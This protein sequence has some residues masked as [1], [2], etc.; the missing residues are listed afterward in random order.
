MDPC[1]PEL[2]FLHFC[3]QPGVDAECCKRFPQAKAMYGLTGQHG[4]IC[5]S[6]QKHQQKQRCLAL[7]IVDYQGDAILTIWCGMCGMTLQRTTFHPLAA[8]C[9]P[10]LS[11]SFTK[12]NTLWLNGTIEGEG[13]IRKKRRQNHSAFAAILESS[14]QEQDQLRN[15][16][17]IQATCRRRS[18]RQNPGVPG[19]RTSKLQTFEVFGDR[20]QNR[21][22]KD[23]NKPPCFLKQW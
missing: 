5:E 1:W 9:L 23:Q 10:V 18:D 20:V 15:V 8:Y 12:N 16:Q 19:F 13:D 11:W 6:G 17:C 14:S 4:D 3:V 21:P 2:C 22:D 7:R